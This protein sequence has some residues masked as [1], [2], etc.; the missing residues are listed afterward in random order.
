MPSVPLLPEVIF[1]IS[2]NDGASAF[3]NIFYGCD[4]WDLAHLVTLA[5]TRGD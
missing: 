4:L 3:I 2:L 5:S 1:L